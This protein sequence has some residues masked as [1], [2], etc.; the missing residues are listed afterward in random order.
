MEFATIENLTGLYDARFFQNVFQQYGH[1]LT[2]GKPF[3][4]EGLVEEDLVEWTLTVKRIEVVNYLIPMTR[5]VS[6][7]PGP[8]AAIGCDKVF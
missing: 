4:G 8:A 5:K 1:L 7:R 6:N 3:V 2:D